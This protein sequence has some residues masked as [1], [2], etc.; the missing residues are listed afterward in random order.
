MAGV[1][2]SL[3]AGRGLTTGGASVSKALADALRLKKEQEQRMKELDFQRAMQLELEKQREKAA[4]EQML[5]QYGLQAATEAMR[6]GSLSPDDYRAILPSFTSPDAANPQGGLDLLGQATWKKRII[7]E[8]EQDKDKALE[9]GRQAL[10]FVQDPEQAAALQEAINAGD[11]QR[12]L[13]I[14][15]KLSIPWNEITFATAQAQAEGAK[16]AAEKAK[17]DVNFLRDTY[18]DRIAKLK[19]DLKLTDAQVDQLIQNI[20]ITAERWGLEKEAFEKDNKLKDVI[21][22]YNK[23]QLEQF[24]ATDPEVRKQAALRT[25]QMEEELASRILDNEFAEIRNKKGQA[26]YEEFIA[27]RGLRL[28]AQ[29]SDLAKTNPE[30]AKKYVEDNKDIIR[31]AGLDPNALKKDADWWDKVRQY[32]DPERQSALNTWSAAMQTPPPKDIDTALQNIYQQLKD[33]GIPEGEAQ[34]L[35]GL[36]DAQWN[37]LLSDYQAKYAELK[38]QLD[39]AKAGGTDPLKLIEARRKI[40]AERK[41]LLNKQRQAIT[42]KARAQRCISDFGGIVNEE[43]C[44]PFKDEYVAVQQQLTQL[45]SEFVALESLLSSGSTDTQGGTSFTPEEVKAGQELDAIVNNFKAKNGV[46]LSADLAAQYL[47][48]NGVRDF[49]IPTLIASLKQRGLVADVN[50]SLI[51]DLAG[52]LD[53]LK[54]LAVYKAVTGE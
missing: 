15:S 28:G 50:E 48:E 47:R 38:A 23:A 41:D 31:D 10:Q 32:Q 53:S 29:I 30:L 17:L 51:P 4:F 25:K 44:K 2:G 40:L 36:L 43:R 45:D 18:N 54:G 14:T 52:K 37:G 27:T 21:Y 19:A 46:P 6:Q 5:A 9:L 33:S 1:F 22:E 12:V 3:A 16:A 26:D 49:V 20:A 13:A 11:P 34:N 35:I 8:A 7:D 24:L 39:A 42:D